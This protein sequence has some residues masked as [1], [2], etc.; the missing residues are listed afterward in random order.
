MSFSDNSS[1][2]NESANS[3]SLRGYL[4]IWGGQSISLLGSQIVQF[5][6]IFW[7][8]IVTQSVLMLALATFLG[9]VPSVILSPI[10]GVIVDRWN[11]KIMIILMDFAQAGATLVLI[12]LF[13]LDLVEVWHVLLLLAIRGGFQAFQS[14]ALFAIVPTMVPKAQ[15][16]KIN[17]LNQTLAG[18]LSIVSPVIGAIMVGN[19]ITVIDKQIGNILWIDVITF[20]FAFG[21]II[22]VTV[23]KLVKQDEDRSSFKVELTEGFSFIKTSGLTPFIAMFASFFALTIPLINFL[24]IFVIDIHN[25]LASDLAMLMG[26]FWVGIMIG[27][28]IIMVLNIQARVQIV[29]GSTF[30]LILGMITIPLA[31]EGNWVI[32]AVGLAVIGISVGIIQVVSLSILQLVIP[33]N[34]QGR[35]SAVIMGTLIPALLP[36]VIIVA[37]V[38]GEIFGLTLVYWLTPLFCVI[39]EIIVIEKGQILKL[40]EKLGLITLEEIAHCRSTYFKAAKNI[41]NV[42]LDH[43]S[44]R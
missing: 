1:V 9:L 15:L 31:P 37:G 19:D 28:S 3:S 24:P 39:I 12:T 20:L 8:T 21:A 4:S 23:P 41:K 35:V 13:M 42:L 25:G 40:D 14:P 43:V 30:F 11:R 18:L 33:E 22:L 32:L 26:I 38:I 10:S 27:A 44:W 34:L 5:A 16:N 6:I 17:G 2:E 29:V 36:T 7:L